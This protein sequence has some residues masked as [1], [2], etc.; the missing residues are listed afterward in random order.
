MASRSLPKITRGA[1]WLLI[2]TTALSL[3][4]IVIGPEVNAVATHWLLA[5]PTSLWKRGFVWQIFTSPLFEPEVIGILFQGFM[6]WMFLPSLEKWRGTKRFL[7]FCLYTS[8]A[9]VLAGTLV[10]LF[11]GQP[12]IPAAGLDPFIFGSLIAFGIL[13][14][15]QPVQ[16][17]GVLPMTGKQLA[18]GISAVTLLLIVVGRQWV[19]G[20]ANVGAM[21]MAVLVCAVLRLYFFNLSNLF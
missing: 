18:I 3:G 17:F 12:D 5:T 21:L 8:I 9:G 1:K 14:S 20:G 6:L 4:L 15:K 2:I 16:F 11:L 13:F 10:G 19:Q 7:F